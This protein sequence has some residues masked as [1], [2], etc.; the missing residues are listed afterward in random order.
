MVQY[1]MVEIKS[2]CSTVWSRGWEC[3]V[4]F[5]LVQGGAMFGVA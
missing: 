4:L 3:A 1:S 2:V 5:Y